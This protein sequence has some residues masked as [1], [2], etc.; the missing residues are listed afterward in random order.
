L[1]AETGQEFM[2]RVLQEAAGPVMLLVTSP[3]TIDR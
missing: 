2:A 3:L 1:L